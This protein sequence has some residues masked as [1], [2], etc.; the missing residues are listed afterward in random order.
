MGIF[1]GYQRLKVYNIQEDEVRVKLDRH[2]RTLTLL[3]LEGEG[4]VCN[5]D[6]HETV[7]TSAVDK[8]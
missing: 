6:S 7:I 4:D 3:Q 5:L 1:T 8:D 2:L